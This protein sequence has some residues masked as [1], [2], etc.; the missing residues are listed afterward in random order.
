MGFSRGRNQSLVVYPQRVTETG[1]MKILFLSEM[2]YPHGSGAE[3]A[4][5]LWMKLL[6]ESGDSVRTITNRFEGESERSS[7]ANLEI[8]RLPLLDGGSVKYSVLGKIGILLSSTIRNAMKWADVVYVP[9]FWY[10]AHV[11]AKIYRKPVVTHL[12]DYIPNCSLGIR[13]NLRTNMA[14]ASIGYCRPSC[15][16]SFEKASRRPCGQVL[17]SVLLNF[18]LW[19]F[20]GL[21][22][23][24]SNKIVCVSDAQR[25]IVVTCMP[26]LAS[27]CEVIYNPICIPKHATRMTECNFGYLGGPSYLKGYDVLRRALKFTR[28]GVTVH[29]TGFSQLPSD[30]S[31]GKSRVVHHVRMRRSNYE[32]LFSKLRAVIVP[33]VWPEPLPYVVAE[34]ALRARIVIASRVGGIPEL[35]EGCPGVF[36]FPPNNHVELANLIDYTSRLDGLTASRLGEENR[37]IMLKRL[38]NHSNLIR[39]QSLLRDAAGMR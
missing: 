39:F 29:V 6:A 17:K 25:D 31:I 4:T 16:V 14:C 32:R 35:T 13:Y 34:A 9:R 5:S 20:V 27:K 38:D 36:L 22:I 12:H 1:R 21:T 11:L 19:R 24:L 26:A 2:I 33:S 37:Q 28:S 15:I 10:M 18:C 3:L 8:Y 7:S 23:F 30:D